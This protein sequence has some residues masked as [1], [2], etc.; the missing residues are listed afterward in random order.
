MDLN[1]AHHV[2]LNFS[3]VLY[4]KTLSDGQDILLPKNGDWNAIKTYIKQ[5]LFV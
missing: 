2:G 5:N 1:N 3:N 4:D